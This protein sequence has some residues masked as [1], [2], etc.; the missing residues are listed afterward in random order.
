MRLYRFFNP[1]VQRS[2]PRSQFSAIPVAV[3]GALEELHRIL[4][5]SQLSIGRFHLSPHAADAGVALERVGPPLGFLVH[6]PQHIAPALLG[7]A[8]LLGHDV[9][10][11]IRTVQ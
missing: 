2:R 5:L 6:H 9:W 10:A 8:Q 4:G 11:E 1:P 7:C 3:D